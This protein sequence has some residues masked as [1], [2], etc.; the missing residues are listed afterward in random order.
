[1]NELCNTRIESNDDR[2][3][4]PAFVTNSMPP[5]QFFENLGTLG[6]APVTHL[7]LITHYLLLN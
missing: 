3:S 1:M 5:P 4:V 6:G 7:S 2:E